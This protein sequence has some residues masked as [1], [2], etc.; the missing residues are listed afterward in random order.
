MKLNAFA[1]GA[2]AGFEATVY[3]YEFP[4]KPIPAK[5]PGI[6]QDELLF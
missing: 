2:S 1:Y 5:R 3:G 6:F 4:P